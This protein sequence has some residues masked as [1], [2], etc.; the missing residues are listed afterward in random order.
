MAVLADKTGIR[1]ILTDHS[2]RCLKPDALQCRNDGL[3]FVFG[4]LSRRIARRFSI[5]IGVG[6]IRKAEVACQALT[7]DDVD[8]ILATGPP[9]SPFALAKRLSD[10]LG[11]PYVLDYRDPW[12]GNPHADLARRPAVVQ[13][14]AEL[15]A[16]SAAVT[17][18]SPSWAS[19]LAA[20]F[21]VATKL[22]V[23]TNGYDPEEL[24]NVKPLEFGHFAIVYAGQFYPP[25]RVITPVMA[26]L[27]RL[28]NIRNGNWRFH[29]YGPHDDHV[30]EE[31]DR[32][33]V[34]GQVVLHGSIA[35]GGVLS[36]V[37]GA[38][39]TVVI[40]SV[41]E[42]PEEADMGIVPGKTFEAIGLGRRT[43]L[44]APAGSD[45]EKIAEATGLVDR[46]AGSEIDRIASFLADCLRGSVAA[47]RQ[48]ET[49]AW[50]TIASKLDVLLRIVVRKTQTAD[51]FARSAG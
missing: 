16:S 32:F 12:T 4:G 34:A 38:G 9:F 7:P 44:I 25:K 10:R 11:R 13:K 14:E 42:S 8:V 45:I 51:R 30:R 29:Y 24:E 41:G 5:D 49:Y 36:A 46:F 1:R 48:P 39:L 27:K 43:L 26:A 21:G 33:S 17:I 40:T 23:I 20:R 2:W 35:R 19:A 6:W 47:A 15:L 37:K 28:K 50:A 31:A 3:A 22:H 18:V